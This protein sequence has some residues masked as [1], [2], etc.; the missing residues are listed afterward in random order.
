[1]I[2]NL[3]NRLTEKLLSTGSISEDEQELYIYGFFMLLS[4]LMYLILACFL[5]LVFG[6]IAESLVF[7]IAFQFIRRYAGGYHTKTEIRCTVASSLSMAICIAVINLSKLYTI[8]NALL[9]LALI[10][11]ACILFLCPIDTPEKPLSQKERRYFRKISWAILIGLL[12][13]VLISYI[14]D[15][16]VLFSPCCMTL[17]LESVLLVAASIKQQV[18]KR[19]KRASKKRE[20]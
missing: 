20:N 6:C 9:I 3:A 7:F 16:A 14:K 4:S 13:A 18:I 12:A 2:N 15:W 10:S 5:G 8:K 17:V 19:N 11:A 1:M